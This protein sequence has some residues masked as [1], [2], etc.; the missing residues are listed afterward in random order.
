MGQFWP[1]LVQMCPV[2]WEKNGDK[3]TH[4]HTHTD[5]RGTTQPGPGTYSICLKTAFSF[6]FCASRKVLQLTILNSFR[7]ACHFSIIFFTVTG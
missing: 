1:I 7:I 6:F 5:D 3:H 4:T 2:V